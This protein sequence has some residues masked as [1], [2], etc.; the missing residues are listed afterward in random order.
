MGILIPGHTVYHVSCQV[1]DKAEDKAD[2]KANPYLQVDDAATGAGQA[3]HLAK[4]KRSF[5]L[6]TPRSV[7]VRQPQSV[8]PKAAAAAKG[9]SAAPSAVGLT[10]STDVS[11]AD[12]PKPDAPKDTPTE[13]APDGPKSQDF[14]RS[15]MATKQ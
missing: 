8:V 6:G 3:K 5:F 12:V 9:Q 13:S 10:P 11:M 2:T 15:L 7:A 4:H 1:E 14:F